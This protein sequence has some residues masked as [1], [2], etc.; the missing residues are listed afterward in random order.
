MKPFVIN[1]DSWHF[2]LN[3]NFVNEHPEW[4]WLQDH[5]DFCSYW[6]ATIFRVIFAMLLAFVGF[7][8][9][10]TLVYG[11]YTEPLKALIIAGILI[12]IIAGI[13]LFS[14][15]YHYMQMRKY[16]AGDKNEEDK[17]ESLLM[18]K[19]RAHKAKICPMVEYK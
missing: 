15:I 18:Q 3:M 5:P 14:L 9:L 19:Y 2:R 1:K 7:S 10:F 6:R 11:A 8:F 17:P 13:A 4:R 16:K 12:A